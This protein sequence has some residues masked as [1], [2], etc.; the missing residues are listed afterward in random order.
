MNLPEYFKN[1]EEDVHKIYDLA[2]EARKKGLDP[3]SD[4]EIS[5]ASSLAERAI[6][7]VETKYPQLKNE[8]MLKLLILLKKNFMNQKIGLLKNL[9]NNWIFSITRTNNHIL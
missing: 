1:L 2:A 7:V 9:T 6:G 5:L 8:K 4:V 3:V